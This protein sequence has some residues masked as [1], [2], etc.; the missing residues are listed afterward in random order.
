MEQPAILNIT[1]TD[2]AYRFRLDLPDSPTSI[3][4]DYTTELTNEIRE[5]L[6]R[7]LQT[8]T[9]SMN[10]LAQA[11]A[12]R[13]TVK[14]G[15]VNETLVTLGRF[16]FETLLPIPIQEMLRH[17]DTALILNTNTPDVPWE[18]LFDAHSKQGH[19]IAQYASVGRI[20]QNGR[21]M[22]HRAS[23]P[24]RPARK[25][26]RREAQ[27][28]SVLFLVNPTGERSSAEE[29]VATLCTT[30][31]ESITRIILYRQQA[32]QLEMRMRL[33]AD[34]PHVIHYAGPF[35]LANPTGEPVLALA[36]NSRL[37][38]GAVEQLFQSLPKRP[39]IFL[40]YHDD[41]R[42]SR[43][44]HPLPNQQERDEMMERVATN[45]LGSRSGF[46]CRV[47]LARQYAT[48]P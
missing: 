30:L 29:E 33:S 1:R 34:N 31:P 17:L 3:G 42:Q 28:L 48:Y 25:L 19:Y 41:E 2:T 15:A 14:L 10:T 18:L 7:N 13:Q 47:T 32:N 4:Q 43:N 22:L 24:E 36:G 9:Q 44:G 26:G 16:L 39:L 35:P 6:R 37:D 12:K 23:F 11:E 45:L 27:G 8:A 38:G 20:A 40:S 21:D 46:D 5:R